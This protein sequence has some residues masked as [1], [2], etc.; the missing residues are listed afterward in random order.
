M[1]LHYPLWFNILF[2]AS[3]YTEIKTTSN[4]LINS[5]CIEIVKEQLMGDWNP[6]KHCKLFLDSYENYLDIGR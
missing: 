1:A 5:L 4:S 3:R 6:Y 2:R